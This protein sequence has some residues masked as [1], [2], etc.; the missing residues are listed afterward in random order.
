MRNKQ[1]ILA[2]RPRGWAEESNF[3]LIEEEVPEVG[4]GQVLTRIHWLSLDPYMRG[5]MD[6]ARSYAAPQALGRVMIGGTVGEVI[7][8]RNPRFHPGEMVVGTGGWQ[9]YDLGDGATLRKVDTSVIPASAYL[10]CVG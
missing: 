1:I 9:Q 6:D 8:S 7:A 3:Q 10:G 5:R 4:D 2:S